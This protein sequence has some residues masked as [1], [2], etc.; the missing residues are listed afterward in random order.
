M[1]ATEVENPIPADEAAEPDLSW[2]ELLA[3]YRRGPKERWSGL[4][5]DSLGPWLT[6]AKKTL[7]AVPPFL[8]AEDVAQQLALEVLRLADRK[9]VV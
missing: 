4:L 6:N 7:P 3:A 2:S 5:L 8:D 1:D 9:S